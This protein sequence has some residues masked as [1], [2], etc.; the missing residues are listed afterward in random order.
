[1]AENAELSTTTGATE[2]TKAAGAGLNLDRIL[3]ALRRGDLAFALAVVMLLV[4]LT[5]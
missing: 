4:V 2:T 3:H 5:S 1:M